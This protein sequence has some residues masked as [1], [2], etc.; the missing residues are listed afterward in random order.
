[1]MVIKL[2]VTHIRLWSVV[3]A[4]NFDLNETLSGWPPLTRIQ[5][6]V[7]ASALFWEEIRAVPEVVSWLLI[8]GLQ[9]IIFSDN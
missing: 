4:R 3:T 8:A 9:E 5:M 1:M 2:L 6:I 7:R